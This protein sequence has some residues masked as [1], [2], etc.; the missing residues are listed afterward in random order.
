M[1]HYRFHVLGGVALLVFGIAV[2][3]FSFGWPP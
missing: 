1:D 2:V 3:L